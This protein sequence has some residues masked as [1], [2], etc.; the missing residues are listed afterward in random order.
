[1]YIQ[2]EHE[3]YV[4]LGTLHEVQIRNEPRDVTSWGD[5]NIRL[6]PA[7]WAEARYTVVGTLPLPSA[8]RRF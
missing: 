8:L 2:D 4:P 6:A 1:V 7:Y 3:M 5:T